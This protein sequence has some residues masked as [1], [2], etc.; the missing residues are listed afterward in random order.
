MAD[1]DTPTLNKAQRRDSEK[2]YES[3]DSLRSTVAEAVAPKVDSIAKKS[4]KQIKTQEKAAAKQEK[5]QNVAAKAQESAANKQKEIAGKLQQTAKQTQENVMSQ[6]M[7]TVIG[8]MKLALDPLQEIAGIDLLGSIQS[9]VGLGKD[10]IKEKGAQGKGKSED[11]TIA[12]TRR[13]EVVR[14][15]PWAV[16]LA[17]ELKE[18]D[19][20][21]AKDSEDGMGEM[22]SGLFG[23]AGAGGLGGKLSGLLSGTAFGIGSL[24]VGLGWSIVEG[25]RGWINSEEWGVSNIAGAIGGFFGGQGDGG[26]KDAFAGAGRW[27]LVGAGIGSIFPVVGTIAGGLIGAALGGILGFIGGENIA[28][29]L[30]GMGEK[31][32]ELWNSFLDSDFFSVM[33]N[34]FSSIFDLVISPFEGAY[35]QIREV[36]GNIVD[37]AG[38]DDKSIG[39]KIG[40]IVWEIVSAGPRMIFGWFEGLGEGI[41]NYIQDWFGEDG[42]MSQIGDM[43]E[44]LID[45]LANIG[46]EFVDWVI[47]P[48]RGAFEGFKEEG[49][50]GAIKGWFG[51]LWGNLV[52]LIGSIFG[53]EDDLISGDDES[54]MMENIVS[55]LLDIGDQVWSFITDFVGGFVSGIGNI[56]SSV[57]NWSTENLVEPVREFFEELPGNIREGVSGFVSTASTFIGENIVDPVSNFFTDVSGNI[58]EGVSG[59]VSNA[60]DF[61]GE[62]IVDPV[63]DF[64]SDIP[65][66]V[67]EGVSDFFN[68][69]GERI[70]EWLIEPVD[71]FFSGIADR[72]PSLSD[73]REGAGD[74]AGNVG[75]W[76]RNR[77]PFGNEESA[78]DAVITSSGDLIHTDPDDNI[79]A[80]QNPINLQE[81]GFNENSLNEASQELRSNTGRTEEKERW[82]EV[83]SLIQRVA[84]AMERSGSSDGNSQQIAPSVN[85]DNLRLAVEQ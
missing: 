22:L 8:P 38:D 67:Q 28:K 39:A 52:N 7:D 19:K 50:S 25:V 26:I 12:D 48:F 82:D 54:E 14:Q 80:T 64:F 49:V 29:G 1:Q 81:G 5:F 57:M 45:Y 32:S 51:G 24:V 40:G 33:S 34:M 58:R 72:I 41:I 21:K 66:N 36:I 78:E 47:S 84:T 37:I 60:S 10:K 55:T 65:G 59:F 61:I 62:N 75:D 70:Q 42:I 76:V 53:M 3:L 17:E 85:F 43:A 73:L 27:A 83:V 63:R 31:L 6:A 77:W 71:E 13:R 9:L 2:L 44:P 69:F 56:G 46:S 16:F 30:D 35:D 20:D 23:G 68:G 11:G 18:E 15:A 4:E 79:I 74:A